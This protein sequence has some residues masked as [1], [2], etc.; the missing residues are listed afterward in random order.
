MIALV[1][2]TLILCGKMMEF[3]C[4]ALQRDIQLL[5]LKGSGIR[6]AH[7]GEGLPPPR[8]TRHFTVK[9]TCMR[10]LVLFTCQDLIAEVTEDWREENE[11]KG[12]INVKLVEADQA[13]KIVTGH[14]RDAGLYV[15]VRI[16]IY[17]YIL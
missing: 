10:I 13:D 4:N 14:R 15:Y 17:V 2:I 6:W 1:R 11:Y 5:I 7:G 3:V 8:A 16:Y 9:L 12:V